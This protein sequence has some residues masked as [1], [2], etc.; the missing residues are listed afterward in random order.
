MHSS[1]VA[2]AASAAA[3]DDAAAA[4]SAVAR[5]GRGGSV[6]GGAV[7]RD[8]AAAHSAQRRRPGGLT[9]WQ[10]V[11]RQPGHVSASAS[12]SG[13]SVLPKSNAV[14][15][16]ARLGGAAAAAE[17]AHHLADHRARRAGELVGEGWC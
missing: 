6:P 16:E 17:R 12:A 14:G 7:A 8:A 15:H 9:T 11:Q 3:T 13:V 1:S 2:A 5:R 10:L 4:A